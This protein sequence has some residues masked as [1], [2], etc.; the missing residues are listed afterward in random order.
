[1]KSK[2]KKTYPDFGPPECL[3]EKNRGIF[4]PQSEADLLI[5]RLLWILQPETIYN[6]DP[7][8]AAEDALNRSRLRARDLL[9]QMLNHLPKDH[10]AIGDINKALLKNN[11]LNISV[12]I[13]REAPGEFSKIEESPHKIEALELIEKYIEDHE[14]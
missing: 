9:F 5:K 6:T 11:L 12:G 3:S 8:E 14:S 7:K 1:M 4:I 10:L 2:Q 13:D